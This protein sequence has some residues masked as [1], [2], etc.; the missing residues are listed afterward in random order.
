MRFQNI[1]I[2]TFF[3]F[4]AFFTVKVSAANIKI[5]IDREYTVIGD[6]NVNIKEQR[7]VR[8]FNSDKILIKEGNEEVFTITALYKDSDNKNLLEQMVSTVRVNGGSGILTYKVEYSQ[9]NTT[10]Y[11]KVPYPEAIQSNSSYTFNFEYTNLQLATKNGAL[12]DIYI[13]AFRNDIN[14]NTSNVD[15]DYKTRLKV[16]KSLGIENFVVPTPSFKTEESGFDI[17]N[18]TKESLIGTYVWVQRGNVQYYNFTI[19]QNIKKTEEINTG[20]KNEY[21]MILP[22]DMEGLQISQKVYF[23]KLNPRPSYIEYDEE[24]NL[25]GVFK[26]ASHLDSVISIEGVA[27]VSTTGKPNL[28]SSG[29]LSDLNN[30]LDPRYYSAAPYWE[31]DSDAILAKANELKGDK[32]N[33]YDIMLA[34][35]N[36]IVDSIDYSN[37]KRFGINERQGALKTLQGGAAVC[38]EY[39]DLYIALLRAEGIP[40]RAAFGYGYDSRSPSDEQ[41]LHQWTQVYLPAYNKWI[42]VDVTWGESG[43]V[44]IGGDM[45]HFLTHVAS[46]EPNTPATLSGRTFGTKINFDPVAFNI[47]VTEIMPDTSTMQTYSSLMNIYPKPDSGDINLFLDNLSSKISAGIDSFRTDGLNLQNSAQV[48]LFTIL[49]ILLITL[50]FLTTMIVRIIKKVEKKRL[51]SLNSLDTQKFKATL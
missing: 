45:N 8:N 40:T 6:K 9:D 20:N 41:E 27:V 14:F 42:D 37:V 18:F 43:P 49:G 26:L 24:G 47:T 48:V 38:M 46:I 34:S 17:Y 30:R 39:S 4:L 2:T 13:Q 25:I 22:R 31:S 33:I 32:T 11:I 28:K 12:F 7:I 1:L 5:D 36:Y 3:I 10:A 44:L 29:D 23:S 16:P 50:I 19:K 15:Y 51:H 21:R 35:Y